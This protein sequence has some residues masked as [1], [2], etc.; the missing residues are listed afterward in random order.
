VAT[1]PATNNPLPMVAQNPQSYTIASGDTLSGIAKK[2][3][4]VTVKTILEA[5]P[6]I[7]PTKLRPGQVIHLPPPAPAA[8]TMIASASMST[9]SATAEGDQVYTVQ[10]GDTLTRLAG[11]FNTSVRA[12]RSANPTLSTDRIIVGQKLKIPAH[13]T[14]TPMATP[15]VTASARPAA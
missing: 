8:P 5:N 12:I 1:S 6:G 9:P 4:G 11:K 10:S 15:A 2:N 3:P 13:S 7:E 14:P